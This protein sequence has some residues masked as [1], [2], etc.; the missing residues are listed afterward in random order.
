MDRVNALVTNVV[1]GGTIE[2][3]V[4]YLDPFNVF[5]YGPFETVRIEGRDVDELGGAEETLAAKTELELEVLNKLVR[6][7]ISERDRAGQL[8]AT[9]TAFS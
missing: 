5:T 7:E 6:L 1:D 9:Y 3:E 8:I 4:K 2:V